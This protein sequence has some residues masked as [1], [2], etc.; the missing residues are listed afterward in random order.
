M[1]EQAGQSVVKVAHSR[2]AAVFGCPAD[3]GRG[4]RREAAICQAALELINEA[5]YESVT[6]DAVAARAKASKAT[7]YRRWSNKDQLLIDA[8]RRVFA[9]RDAVVPDTGSLRG[10]LMSVSASQADDPVMVMTNI[11]AIKA[12]AFAADAQPRFAAE[13]RTTLED[14]QLQAWQLLLGRAHA[15]G[16]F[17]TPVPARVVWKVAQAQFCART[18]VQPGPIDAAY[19]EHVI[20]DILIPVITHAG[21]VR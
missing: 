21:R 16:D 19:I 6:M 18:G 9:G 4:A 14:A 17:P 13:I 8:L 2:F 15:R 20:D 10:D 7:I 3:A 5:S 11:A 12:L 1:R